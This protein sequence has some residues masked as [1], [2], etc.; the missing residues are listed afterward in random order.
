[1]LKP[2]MKSDALRLLMGEL[3]PDEVRVARAAIC[4]ANLSFQDSVLEMLEGMAVME[5]GQAW[6]R[7]YNTALNKA[8]AK[9]KEMR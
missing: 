4:C 9:I 5:L 2:N 7:G 3:N 6:E 8:I 1:M